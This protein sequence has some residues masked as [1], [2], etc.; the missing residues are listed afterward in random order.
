MLEFYP[1]YAPADLAIR[2]LHASLQ[3]DA[4]SQCSSLQDVKDILAEFPAHIDD[5]YHR[6][7]QRICGQT[8]RQIWLAKAVLVWVL[9]ASRSMTVDELRQAVAASHDQVNHQFEPGQLVSETTLI[10]LC[11]GLVVVEE[12]SRLVRLVRE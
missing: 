8:S 7:W 11:C 12:E 9:N 6:T 2:F 1:T 5:V 10:T 4:I 3:L